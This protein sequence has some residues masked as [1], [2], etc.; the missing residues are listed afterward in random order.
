MIRT[1]IAPSPTGLPHIGTIFQA[2]I[3]YAFAKKHG[4]KS[5]QF[6]V[7]IEDTDQSRLVKGAEQALF[8]ALDWFGLTPDEK[9]YRQSERLKIYQKHAQQLIDKQKA[10]YCFCSSDRLDKIRKQMQKDGQS[11]M[12]DGHC[13]NL[14]AK[15]VTEKLNK[16]QSYVIRMKIGKTSDPIILHDS[17]RGDI[18][19]D[20]N[21][22]D[23]QILL[24]SD[25]YPT[26][27][28][29]V[30]VDDHLMKITHVIRGEEWISSAPKHVLLYQYF[31]WSPPEFI[32]TP[33]LRNPDKSKLSKRHDHASVHWY[34][35]KGYL[36]SAILNSLATRVWNHPQNKEIFNL[37]EFIKHFKFKDMH[38]QSPVVDLDKL[39]W[40]NGVY[41]RNLSDIELLNYAKPF[42]PKNLPDEKLKQILPLIKQRIEYLSQIKD[43]TEYFIKDIKADVKLIKQQSK[44]PTSEIKPVLKQIYSAYSAVSDTDWQADKLDKVGHKLLETTGW[45]P[46]ELFMT[47]RVIV[48]A[49]TATPP[50][51]DTMAVLGRTMVFNRITQAAKNI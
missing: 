32:H 44:K 38:I 11:P 3:N 5:G 51:F 21:V 27:H 16:K 34:Q 40:Y 20:R 30:V 2:L 13:K 33:L 17:I 37:Q 22:I 9:T 41:I 35:E 1:R 36:P 25:G 45:K 42:K 19:F 12:Y 24:K 8:K 26:Y 43:L 46:R 14:T 48:T 31:G 15:E 6:I 47:I 7:R 10:Y 23:D 49:R 18:Q 29:A 28:L 4:D 50:L 39:N